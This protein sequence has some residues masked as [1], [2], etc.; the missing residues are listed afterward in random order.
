MSC[1][2]Y[3][4]MTAWA[5]VKRCIRMLLAMLITA[6]EVASKSHKGAHSGKMEQQSDK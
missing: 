3:D 4:A 5:C 6:R 2:R 1:S